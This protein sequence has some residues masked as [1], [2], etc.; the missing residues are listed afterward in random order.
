MSDGQTLP[1]FSGKW[2]LIDVAGASPNVGPVV[3]E[4]AQ[5][6]S[7]GG[8]LFLIGRATEIAE[9]LA[10]VETAVAWD[11]VSHYQVFDSREHYMER[12][13]RHRPTLRERLFGR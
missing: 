9:W 4:S 6:R 7:Y 5:F 13:K 1:D 8:R 10:G 12:V 3:M 2:V 11:N